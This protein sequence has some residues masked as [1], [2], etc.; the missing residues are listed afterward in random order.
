[1]KQLDKIIEEQTQSLIESGKVEEM[2]SQKLEATIKDCIDDCLKSWSD[3]GKGLKEQIAESV[4]M[5]EIS[6]PQYHLFIKET[7]ERRFVEILKEDHLKHLND[8]LGELILPIQ[9]EIKSSEIIKMIEDSWREDAL[10]HGAEYIE[11]KVDRGYESI[12]LTLVHPEYDWQ[13]IKVTMYNFD[14]CPDEDWCI[15][16]ISEKEK[17]FTKNAKE[18]AGYATSRLMDKLFLLYASRTNIV[19]DQ[20]FDDICVVDY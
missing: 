3:F 13:S 16:Y 8:V 18:V 17:S 12:R 7:I 20:D 5:T 6:L 2:I 9:K 1:M 4:K 11:I 19:I 15:G 10:Q 14:S